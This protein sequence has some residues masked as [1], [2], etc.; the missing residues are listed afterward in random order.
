MDSVELL[1]ED[2]VEERLRADWATLLEA[3]LPS[4]ARHA[5][6]SNRP[7]ITLLAAP[8]IPSD[9]DLA[10]AGIAHSLPLP[11][12]VA[13]LVIFRTGRGH[14]LARLGVV[15]D[16]LM[17]FHREI[18]QALGDVPNIAAN[19]LP[20]RWVPHITLARGLSG[21]QIS[22]ALDLLPAEHGRVAVTSLR[23][24]NSRDRTTTALASR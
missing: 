7:H 11:M 18:H 3:N 21:E 6:E 8:A 16:A 24:W 23:R 5:A 15:S 14:V 9:A 12:A 20:D 17:H 4:Q 10:L 1:L 2:S 13:G 19:C 22:R